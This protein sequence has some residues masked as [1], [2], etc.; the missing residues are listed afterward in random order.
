MAT[1]NNTRSEHI[2]AQKFPAAL[3]A[4]QAAERAVAQ[5]LEAGYRP[6]PILRPEVSRVVS[7]AASAA[8]RHGPLIERAIGNALE[9][10]GLTVLRNVSIPITRGALALTD[11]LDYAQLVGRQIDFN[12][13]DIADATDADI[14]A[15]DEPHGWAGAFSVKRGGG[16][17][18]TRRRKDSGRQLRALNFTLASWLRK[19]GYR[20][21]ETA[22]AGV[23][24]YFGQSGFAKD[25]T[26]DRNGL[27]DYFGLP[28]V[29]DVDAVTA[30]MFHAMD[31][32]M[33]ALLVPIIAV[34]APVDTPKVAATEEMMTSSVVATLLRP[35]LH[36]ENGAT[37]MA[38]G[39][40]LQR[41]R[42]H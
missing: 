23:I 3:A 35:R 14:I 27:D 1:I 33:E 36:A 7:F 38:A 39:E 32:E 10:G 28:I 20:Q 25:L 37:K 16:Q 19:K 9:C 42:Q 17:T 22:V 15:I 34:I 13:N 4:I 21:V 29:R 41:S 2:L 31:I 24:D 8:K 12:E 18:E 40:T 26:V 6:D 11:S 30:A 5:A